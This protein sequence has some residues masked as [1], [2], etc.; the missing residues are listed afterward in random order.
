MSD[1]NFGF[2]AWVGK[3]V[4]ELAMVVGI[5]AALFVGCFIYAAWI[6]YVPRI[7]RWCAAR[8]KR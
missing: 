4:A 2:W 3:T 5:L 6:T 1:F 7:K 8:G